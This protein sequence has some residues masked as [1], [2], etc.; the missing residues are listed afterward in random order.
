[1]QKYWSNFAKSGNPNG[2]GLPDWPPYAAAD[3]WAVMILNSQPA[4]QKDTWRDRY[5][6]LSKEWGKMKQ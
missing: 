6:F 3:G 2:A 5:R 4:A 1:M